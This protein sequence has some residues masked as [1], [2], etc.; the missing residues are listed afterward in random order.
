MPLAVDAQPGMRILDLCA[1]PGGKTIA[2]A[3][4]AGG[5]VVV[6]SDVRPRRIRTLVQTVAASGAPNVRIVYVPAAGTLPFTT[7]FDRILVDAPCSGLGTLRRRADARWRIDEDAVA[8]LAE[9]QRSLLVEAST[10]V[11]PGGTLVYS[12]CTLTAAEGPEVAATLP[13]PTL[14]APGE[15]WEPWGSGARLLP[16]AAGTDGMFLARWTRPADS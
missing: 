3:A 10:L 8:R 14:D 6:A 4:T 9:L 5:G 13:W 1:S 11:R 15:P 7:T 2:L 16:Q 12:V